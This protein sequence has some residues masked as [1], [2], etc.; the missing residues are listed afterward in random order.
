MW[1]GRIERQT[2][3]DIINKMIKI[4]VAGKSKNG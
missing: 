1:F 2:N 3:D 4:R